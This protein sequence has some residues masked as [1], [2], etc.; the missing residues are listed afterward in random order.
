MKED[1]STLPVSTKQ[2]NQAG[3]KIAKT[4]A[5]KYFC[6]GNFVSF[7]ESYIILL[8]LREVF[9]PSVSQTDAS[10]AAKKNKYHNGNN[11]IDIIDTIN[12]FNLGI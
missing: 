2:I 8:S 9:V 7:C 3:E 5:I 4:I 12:A 1:K 6:K 11:I 10:S